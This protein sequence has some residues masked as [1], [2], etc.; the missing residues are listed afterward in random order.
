MSNDEEWTCGRCG[1]PMEKGYPLDEVVH[2]NTGS[3]CP[4]CLKPTDE[5]VDV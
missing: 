2:P 3:V 5:V 4:D 1:E